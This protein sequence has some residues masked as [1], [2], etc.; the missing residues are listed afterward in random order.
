MTA[1]NHGTVCV[2]KARRRSVC[3]LC[4]AAITVG[5]QI[6]RIGT[7]VIEWAHTRCLIGNH[8]PAA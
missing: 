3:A 8:P 1:V 6:A 5:Q 4:V 2:H 7:T